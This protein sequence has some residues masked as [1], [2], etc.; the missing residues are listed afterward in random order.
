MPLPKHHIFVCINERPEGHP[1]GSCMSQ[2]PLPLLD[3]FRNKIEAEDLWGS[4]KLTR[5]MCMGPCH[6]GPV[7]VVYPEGVWYGNVKPEDAEAIFETHI[8]GGTVLEHLRIPDEE[9]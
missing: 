9:I 4:I 1:K 5:S 7:V 2:N 6:K 3:V 8:K